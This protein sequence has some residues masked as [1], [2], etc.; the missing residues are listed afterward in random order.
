MS[1]GRCVLCLLF[2]ESVRLISAH[3]YSV[4]LCSCHDVTQCHLCLCGIKACLSVR[5]L[6]LPVCLPISGC[7]LVP[8]TYVLDGF[9]LLLSDRGG[10][11]DPLRLIL[12]LPRPLVSCCDVCARMCVCLHCYYIYFISRWCLISV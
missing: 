6:C 4:V 9:T 2:V 7:P 12:L 3:E 1:P 11:L 10:V 5:S 8:F